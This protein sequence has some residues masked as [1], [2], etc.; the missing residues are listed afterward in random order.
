MKF[1]FARVVL[2]LGLFG[3]YTSSVYAKDL[4][5][6]VENTQY[7]PYFSSEGRK[8]NEYRGLAREI[9]EEYGRFN[10]HKI[11]FVPLP[12]KRLY[13]SFLTGKVDFKF[14][15][16]PYWQIDSKKGADIKYSE[17]IMGF[18]D[19]IMLLPEKKGTG[20]AGLKILGTVRGFTAFDYL[21]FINTG[22]VQ[23]EETNTLEGLIQKVLTGRIDGAYVNIA[24]ARYYLQEELGRRNDLV[25]DP[26]LPYTVDYYRLSSIKH[27]NIINEFN[28]FLTRRR[29]VINAIKHRHGVRD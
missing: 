20:L 22:I 27:P 21:E 7:L 8:K 1:A 14:P 4:I 15:D 10:K 6:G 28:Q 3:F 26:I 2:I 23:L 18:T 25:F 19:G 9:L 16:S 29:L 17:G 12:V 11:V 13:K 5:V 24:V